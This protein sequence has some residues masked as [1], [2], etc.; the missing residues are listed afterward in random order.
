QAA[1]LIRSYLL[2]LYRGVSEPEIDQERSKGR[3]ARDDRHQTE[4]IGRQ[5]TGQQKYGDY[6]NGSVA[7]LSSNGRRAAEQS[8]APE[9]SRALMAVEV[10]RIDFGHALSIVP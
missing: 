2:S 4:I 7:E 3:Q 1:D 10:E 9:L 5:E 8:P 6:L